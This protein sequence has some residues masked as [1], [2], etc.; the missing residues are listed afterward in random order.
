VG[1]NETPGF[2]PARWMRARFNS[3]HGQR[4]EA[5]CFK[6]GLEDTRSFGAGSQQFDSHCA[7]RID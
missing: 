6:T 3:P 1:F 7:I 4:A 2:S 5:R